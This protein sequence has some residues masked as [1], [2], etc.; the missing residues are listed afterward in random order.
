MFVD[1]MV[2]VF[3]SLTSCLVLLP[4]SSSQLKELCLHILHRFVFHITKLTTFFAYVCTYVRVY[5]NLISFP[6][7]RGISSN[8]RVDNGAL[9]F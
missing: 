1:V 9:T 6:S 7:L 4:C 3:V 8:K 2:P 5:A